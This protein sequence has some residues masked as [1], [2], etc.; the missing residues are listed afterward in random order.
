MCAV[1]SVSLL[2]GAIDDPTN[3]MGNIGSADVRPA[4]KCS[5]KVL[6]TRSAALRM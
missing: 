4:K 3:I 2:V 5:L 1:S 6:M